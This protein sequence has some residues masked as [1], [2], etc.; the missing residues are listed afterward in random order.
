MSRALNV[1]GADRDEGKST[2]RPD[3]HSQALT[4]LECSQ[5]VKGCKTTDGLRV[6]TRQYLICDDFLEEPKLGFEESIRIV[7]KEGQERELQGGIQCEPWLGVGAT[8]VC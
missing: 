2:P 5:A 3:I 7:W 4:P 8:Q 6:V 1:V